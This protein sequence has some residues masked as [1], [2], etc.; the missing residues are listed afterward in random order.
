MCDTTNLLV[1]AANV[2]SHKYCFG[3]QALSGMYC[4][5]A[6]KQQVRGTGMPLLGLGV[7]RL[8]LF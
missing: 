8:A 7:D 2:E 6:K 1:V 3:P 4:C 5:I